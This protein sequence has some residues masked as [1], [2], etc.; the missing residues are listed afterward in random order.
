M[1]HLSII[2]HSSRLKYLCRKK[3]TKFVRVMTCRWLQR[4]SAFHTQKS[5]C[6]YK[7][8]F[9]VTACT[10][11]SHSQAIH[12]QHSGGYELLFPHEELFTFDCWWARESYF[13]SMKMLMT[14][15]ISFRQDPR[16]ISQCK[17]YS[18]VYKKGAEKSL[19]EWNL[20]IKYS[21]NK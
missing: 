11:L 7:F 5:W 2:T 20:I 16:L 13:S 19:G 1:G 9:I 6:T 8:A 4:R 10:I 21:K 18:T 17:L 12:S 3:K 15:V 14:Y